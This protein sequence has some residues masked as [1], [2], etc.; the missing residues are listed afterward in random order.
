MKPSLWTWVTVT[1][2]LLASHWPLRDDA[3][4]RLTVRTIEIPRLF[5]C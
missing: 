3:S 4:A 5:M 2:T 1:D